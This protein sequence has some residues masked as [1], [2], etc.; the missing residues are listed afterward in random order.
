[1]AVKFT[2]K[3]NIPQEFVDAVT[4]DNHVV[5]GD[6]SVTTLIDAPQVRMLR[7]NT[8]YEID[9]TEQMAMFIGTSI[10]E[11]LESANVFLHRARVLGN[12][13]SILSKIGGEKAIKAS[14]WLVD[15]IKNNIEKLFPSDY[16]IEKTLTLESNGWTVSGTVDRYIKSEKKLRDYKT[17]TASALAFPEQKTSWKLQQNIYAAMLRAIGYEV[18]SIEIVAIVKDW[19]KMKVNSSADYPKAPV[20]IIT[21]EVG[22]NDKVIEYIGK[23]VLIHQRA[24]QGE[25]IPCTKLD[26]WAKE[27]VYAVKKKGG[28][29]AL[30][31]FP[32]KGLAEA[33][34]NENNFKYPPAQALYFEFRPAESFRCK[35]YCAMSSVCPQYKAELEATAEISEETF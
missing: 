18:E 22:N 34:I 7:K 10:H 3:H 2:N 9:V 16:L 11:K 17:I 23:R 8:D 27:D 5:N 21:L 4:L 33:F 32:S 14:V 24:E 28:K 13:A 31:N 19:S 35:N 26:R 12:A 30:R 1:M 20:V 15:F 6:I 29:R 25:N